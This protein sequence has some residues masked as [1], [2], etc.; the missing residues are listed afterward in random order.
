MSRESIAGTALR[1]LCA[2]DFRAFYPAPDLLTRQ[3]TQRSPRPHL[4]VPV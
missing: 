4:N 2:I 1:V 3:C